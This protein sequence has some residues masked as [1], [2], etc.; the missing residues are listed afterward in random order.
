MELDSTRQPAP[1]PIR[2]SDQ[3]TDN[4]SLTGMLHKEI[5]EAKQLNRAA[6]M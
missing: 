3:S 2:P 1:G 5:H 4:L 6:S